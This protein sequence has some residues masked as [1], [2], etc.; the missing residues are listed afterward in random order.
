MGGGGKL[1]YSNFE[2]MPPSPS[3]QVEVH[4]P[5]GYEKRKVL[6]IK[7][8][9]FT[10]TQFMTSVTN[11]FVLT[12]D[13]QWR[14]HQ[15]AWR[16]PC[17]VTTYYYQSQEGLAETDQENSRCSSLWRQTTVSFLGDSLYSNIAYNFE[18]GLFNS[19]QHALIKTA[20]NVLWLHSKLTS[21][22]YQM[23]S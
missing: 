16:H 22:S 10:N 14:R 11:K 20:H 4:E 8:T 6:N 9:A 21:H 12:W 23:S 1:D 17:I 3:T 2:R 18:N 7:L 5:Q 19:P 13:N 15:H